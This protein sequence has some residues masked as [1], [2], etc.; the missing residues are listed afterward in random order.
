MTPAVVLPRVET[1]YG[2]AALLTAR[3][4]TKRFDAALRLSVH[5]VS[6]AL[7]AAAGTTA[8]EH[9]VGPSAKSTYPIALTLIAGDVDDLI[10]GCYGYD[11]V[12]HALVPGQPGDHRR[13][14]A[15]ATLDAG[16]WL[17]AC[18]ALLLLT[19]DLEA[20]RRRFLDQP[21]EHGERFAWME[22]GHAV[23]NVYLT[24]SESRLGTCLVAGVDDEKLATVS[25]ALVPDHHQVLG[26]MALGFAASEQQF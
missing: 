23:Q 19:T 6:A 14:I 1:T 24:A 10:A 17:A 20:A 26:I 25:S 7:W 4:S 2:I 13:P 12:R 21:A 11:P 22:A 8:P 9:R 15:A 3:R 18:P 5:E 16:D